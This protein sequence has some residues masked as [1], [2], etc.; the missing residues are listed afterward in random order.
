[1]NETG[2]VER[3]VE[4]VHDQLPSDGAQWPG[5]WPGEAEAALLD[6]VLSIGTVYGGP[7]TGVRGAVGRWRQ[8][9]EGVPLDDL[10][11]LAAARAQSYW[12]ADAIESSGSSRSAEPSPLAF[13][14]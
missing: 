5:G 4:H 11:A 14:P 3:V 12:A 10:D 8:H 1:V 9:R 2:D 13:M 7:E 6:A